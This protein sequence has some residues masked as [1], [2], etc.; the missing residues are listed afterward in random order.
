MSAAAASEALPE[1]N[2]CG[3]HAGS[4]IEFDIEV[5]HLHKPLYDNSPAYSVQG[6]LPPPAGY[7]LDL[8][9]P[10]VLDILSR[11]QAGH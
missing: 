6:K 4:A 11:M 7:V 3:S 5:R 1:S 10:G 9:V 2:I 8:A